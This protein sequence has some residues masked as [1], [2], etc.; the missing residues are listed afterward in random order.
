[1]KFP[2]LSSLS[3]KHAEVRWALVLLSI[4]RCIPGSSQTLTGTESRGLWSGRVLERMDALPVAQVLV[5]LLDL[6]GYELERTTTVADGGYV[7]PARSG[8]AIVEVCVPGG[9]VMARVV[10]CRSDQKDKR[11]KD[12]YVDSR[13]SLPVFLITRDADNGLPAR[14]AQLT[15]TSRNGARTFLET[16]SDS[17]GVVRGTMDGLRYGREHEVQVNVNKEGYFERS[18]MVDATDLAFYHWE[19]A[20]VKQMVLDPMETGEDAELDTLRTIRRP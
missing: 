7:F 5:R 3:I 13:T 8:A 12:L 16:S 10:A 9:M 4:L 18:A 20:G 17:A 2:F 14:D 19:L 15:I 1:M 11:I 6:N